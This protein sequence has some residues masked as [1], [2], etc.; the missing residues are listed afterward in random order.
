MM[1]RVHFLRGCH[2]FKIAMIVIAV[3]VVGCQEPRDSQKTSLS[4]TASQPLPAEPATVQRVPSKP[5]EFSPDLSPQTLQSL[6][7]HFPGYTLPRSTPRDKSVPSLIQTDSQPYIE[8]SAKPLA[9]AVINGE[10]ERTRQLLQSGHPSDETYHG[11]NLLH[12]AARRGQTEICELLLD[13]GLDV[14]GTSDEE[15]S[16]AQTPLQAAILS[17]SIETVELLLAHGAELAPADV[18]NQRDGP[19]PSP[20]SLAISSG[21]LDMLN[22]I[23]NQGE[24]ADDVKFL[25]QAIVQFMKPALRRQFVERLIAA[26]AAEDIEPNALDL[27]APA[28]A[29]G[30]LRLLQILEAKLPVSYGEPHLR[31]AVQSGD[32]DLCRHLLSKGVRAKPDPTLGNE[33]L[34]IALIDH[35]SPELAELAVKAGEQKK[36]CVQSDA[37]TSYCNR[38]D[39]AHPLYHA[40]MAND[41]KLCSYLI[42]EFSDDPNLWG[43]LIY[44][45]YEYESNIEFFQ[46]GNTILF[47]AV[48]EDHVEALEL[49]LRYTQRPG[50]QPIVDINAQNDVGHTALHE[51]VNF[52]APR[53]TELLLAAGADPTIARND[54]C[55][56]LHIAMRR[57]LIPHHH[58]DIPMPEAMSTM[59]PMLAAATMTSADDQ[60]T[61][62]KNDN[63]E[64]ILH[65]HA[66]A[67]HAKI[68]QKLIELGADVN[69]VDKRGSTPLHHAFYGT[70]EYRSAEEEARYIATCMTLLNNGIDITQPDAS[71]SRHYL[72]QAAAK[73]LYEVYDALLEQNAEPNLAQNAG[74]LMCSAAKF[75]QP[76]RIE[77]LLDWGA[78]IN[79]E[80]F[81]KSTAL[82]QAARFHHLEMCERLIANGADVNARDQ[83][84]Q[85]PLF[86]LFDRWAIHTEP[87]QNKETQTKA[88]AVLRLLLE[89]GAD[90]EIKTNSTTYTSLSGTVEE[91]FQNMPQSFREALQT[92]RGAVRK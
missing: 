70:N 20:V 21:N 15:P 50:Q 42:R 14:H 30:D 90:P 9:E 45:P 92:K 28:I 68:C 60:W 10:V 4:Q 46:K 69:A 79:A 87:L 55:T 3:A 89:H 52:G 86:E 58:S 31:A 76:D 36:Y 32:L 47:A 61:S 91:V 67:G 83:R 81:E 44:E 74:H 26:G 19:A 17:G 34:R 43:S 24:P 8:L 33:L 78:D 54:G 75:D 6:R 11:Q 82:H 27:F 49:L 18:N 22:F 85:T 62:R 1:S 64:T 56:P 66:R 41:L 57:H 88:F 77:Q 7:E 39:F 63:G 73:N 16:P 51:A 5:D 53:C 23:I 29:T 48:F 40:A 65:R 71:A 12:V 13:A 35:R 37:A 80:D 25:H 84:G 38:R 59:F 2:D 72:C